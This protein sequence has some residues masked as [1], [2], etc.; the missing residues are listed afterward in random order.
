MDKDISTQILEKL[1]SIDNRLDKMD[2]RLDKMDTRLDGMD[3]RLDNMESNMKS[4]NTRLVSLEADVHDI[5][6]QQA[7]D[8]NLLRIVFENSIDLTERVT[9]HD[10]KFEEMKA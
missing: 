7:E 2:T 9:S 6:V 1:V 4:M 5:K 8:S 10:M 3:A